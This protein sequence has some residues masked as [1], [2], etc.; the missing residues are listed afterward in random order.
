MFPGSYCASAGGVG[1]GADVDVGADAGADIDV[2]AAK[3]IR[4]PERNGSRRQMKMDAIETGFVSS[5]RAANV[6]VVREAAMAAELLAP[7]STSE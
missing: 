6:R 4:Q 1:V 2:G 7:E 5:R 3:M